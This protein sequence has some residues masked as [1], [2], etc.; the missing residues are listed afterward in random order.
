MEKEFKDETSN[1]VPYGNLETELKQFQ[2]MD[3]DIIQERGTITFT[4]TALL[5]IVCC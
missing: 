5:T 4:C 3:A 2:S 1:Y